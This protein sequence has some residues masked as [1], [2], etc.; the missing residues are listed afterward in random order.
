M[1]E[2]LH[3]CHMDSPS[4]A[5]ALNLSLVGL[6]QHIQYVTYVI[7]SCVRLLT[8]ISKCSLTADINKTFLKRREKIVNM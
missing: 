3:N 5:A 2:P 6:P 4:S 7:K 8:R 1:Q